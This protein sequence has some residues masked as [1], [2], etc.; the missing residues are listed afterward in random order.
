V[1]QAKQDRLREGSIED[2]FPYPLSIRFRNLFAAE[3]SPLPD[4]RAMSKYYK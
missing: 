1:W 4:L 2:V 3:H